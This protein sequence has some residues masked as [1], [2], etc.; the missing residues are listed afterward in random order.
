MTTLEHPGL[1]LPVFRR[2]ILWLLL[3]GIAQVVWAV[4]VFFVSVGPPVWLRSMSSPTFLPG[5]IYSLYSG[6]VAL[7]LLICTGLAH[8]LASRGW[9][10]MA[11][12]ASV[13]P[14]PGVLFGVIQIFPAFVALRH[15][16]DA[17]WENFFHW[18]EKRNR[19]TGRP[20][21]A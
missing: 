18:M 19:L 1:L 12:L 10:R 5:I 11:F 16:G 7:Y 20:P 14:G 3:T 9:L 6:T 21:S 13:L 2:Q 15:L 17:R 8:L 4:A